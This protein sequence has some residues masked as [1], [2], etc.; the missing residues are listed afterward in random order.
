MNILKSKS[1]ILFSSLLLTTCVGISQTKT[2]S[3]VKTETN[4]NKTIKK[5]YQLKRFKQSCCTGIVEFSLK[6]VKGYISSKA[7][8]KN[9]QLTVWFDSSK[10]TEKQIKEAINKTPYKIEK[11]L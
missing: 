5:T 7:N 4:Q 9:Q 11:T 6:K 10:T 1:L 8:V 3:E 2:D